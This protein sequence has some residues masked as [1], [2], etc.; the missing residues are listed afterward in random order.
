MEKNVHVGAGSVMTD[1][2]LGSDNAQNAVASVGVLLG[3]NIARIVRDKIE[4]DFDRTDGAF[5]VNRPVTSFGIVSMA[6][7]GI[8]LETL[9]GGSYPVVNLSVVN[10]DGEPEEFAF[11]PSQ[12]FDFHDKMSD[13]DIVKALSDES[14]GKIWERVFPSPYAASRVAQVYNRIELRR[15]NDIL[16]RYVG[17]KTTLQKIMAATDAPFSDRD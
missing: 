17:I 1:S 12:Y 16:E 6:V 11:S 15:V 7:T 13:A 2:Y 5:R 14:C 10:S 9:G 4:P 8:N 3:K